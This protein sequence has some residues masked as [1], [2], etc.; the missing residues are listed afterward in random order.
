VPLI[1]SE[2]LVV[3]NQQSTD[4]VTLRYTP[5]NSNH[6]DFYRFTLSEPDI[7]VIEKA[8]NDTDRK[9]TFNNLTPGKLYNF[10][11]WTVAD[12][13]LSTPIQRHDRLCEYKF[14]FQHTFWILLLNNITIIII[15][16]VFL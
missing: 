5:Q 7:P 16:K 12:G 14:C 10:T 11:V 1:E 6:F 15:T 9:V 2:V 4:S 3:N 8:A 13:V